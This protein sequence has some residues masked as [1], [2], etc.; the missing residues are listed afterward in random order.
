[1]N[2]IVTIILAGGQSSRCWPLTDKNIINFYPDNLLEY[3]LK[4]LLA[5]G[6]KE[7]IVVCSESVVAYLEK[8]KK[9]VKSLCTI[10]IILQKK[11]KPGIGNA[12]LS[13]SDIIEQKY[14]NFSVYI[15]NCDDIYETSVHQNI[16]SMQKKQQ[17]DVVVAAFEMTGYQ[18]LGYFILDKDKVKGIL[19]KPAKGKTPSN[20]ANMSLHLYTNFSLIKKELHKLSHEK[21]PNDD[22]Y[23]R[24]L[25]N[26]SQ[27]TSVFLYK[28]KNDWLILKYPWQV[29]DVSNFFLKQIKRSIS[30]SAVIDKTVTI[31]GEVVIED[32]V[33]IMESV[34]IVGP[35]VIRKGTL[36][37]NNTVIR[38]SYI[39]ENCVVGFTSEITRSYIGQNCWFH[40]NYVGDSVL[41]SNI[42]MGS[43][44]C[45][46]NLR[47]DQKNIFSSVKSQKMDTQRLKLGAIIGDGVQIGV[48]ASVMPGVKIGKYSQIGPG[49]ILYSDLEERNKIF[50]QQ[51]LIRKSVNSPQNGLQKRSNF[52][53]QL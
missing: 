45:I 36:I 28:Y 43:G 44:A 18:P 23:E 31:S 50:I 40:C 11:S 1:M 42:N 35:S 26:L 8:F 4:A 24:A 14:N 41:E 16:F 39:G 13:A 37:G 53:K 27:T 47:L 5:L 15:I 12:V 2:K 19:E 38:E 20:Y 7:F 3:H 6:C 17:A 32:N 46:S 21:D 22:L 34:K 51:K 52:R 9:S 48:N 49:V 25:T 10:T 29:L 33:R 30:S